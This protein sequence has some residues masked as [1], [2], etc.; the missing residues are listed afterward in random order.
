MSEQKEETQK[1]PSENKK[2]K[3]KQT[4]IWLWV[5]IVAVVIIAGIFTYYYFGNKESQNV[6]Q[7]LTN[8]EDDDAKVVKEVSK[9][10]ILPEETPSLATVLDKT[11]LDG[12]PFFAKA[13]NGDKLML[14][15]GAQKAILYRPA[16]KQIVEVMPLVMNQEVNNE[17]LSN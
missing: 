12:R 16:T 8:L 10:M 9:I 13:E 15:T 11:K 2:N 14:F 7:M 1:K 6:D 5:A 17:A 3:K 4:Q